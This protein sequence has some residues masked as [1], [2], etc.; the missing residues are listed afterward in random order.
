MDISHEIGHLFALTT[1]SD[2]LLVDISYIRIHLN[3]Q[4][5]LVDDTHMSSIAL[6][7]HPIVEF[8]LKDGCTDV[9]KPLLGD[10]R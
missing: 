3:V 6:L 10:F 9:S 7:L 8:T 4:V 5:L 2:G 1:Y